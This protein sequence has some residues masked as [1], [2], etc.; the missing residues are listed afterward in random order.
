MPQEDHETLFTIIANNRTRHIEELTQLLLEETIDNH[1]ERLV[2]EVMF[3][4]NYVYKLA[5]HL[6]PLEIDPELRRYWI[7]KVL[8]GNAVFTSDQFLFVDE[9][10]KKVEGLHATE[11]FCSIW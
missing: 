9:S 6:V 4:K 7:E 2:K 3:K 11:S 5:N 10:S 8:G 1:S